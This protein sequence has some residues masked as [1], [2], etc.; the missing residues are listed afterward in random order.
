MT[1]ELPVGPEMIS[2]MEFSFSFS[3]KTLSHH[4]LPSAPVPFLPCS[5]GFFSCFLSLQAPL[6]LP[7]APACLPLGTQSHLLRPSP[8]SPA[9]VSG[10]VVTG[11]SGGAHL[12]AR[13]VILDKCQPLP[14]DLLKSEGGS[15]DHVISELGAKLHGPLLA[16]NTLVGRAVGKGRM[17]AGGCRRAQAGP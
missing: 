8:L 10:L 16:A 17:C 13:C 1:E 9:G 12:L 3:P 2:P 11:G 15:L 6:S 7:Q 4:S 14:P 5:A